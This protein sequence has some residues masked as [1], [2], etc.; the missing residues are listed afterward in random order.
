MWNGK[1]DFGVQRTGQVL[2]ILPGNVGYA[3]LDRLPLDRVDEMFEKFRDTKA[4]VFDMR[5]YPKST[6]A[7]IAKRLAEKPF[8]AG[9]G[10]RLIVMSPDREAREADL[11]QFPLSDKPKYRGKT[12]LLIDERAISASETTGMWFKSANGTTYIGSASAGADGSVNGF[13]LPLGG[14]QVYFTSEEFMHADGRQL[15]RIGLLPDIEV[16]PTINGIREGRDEVLEKALEFL[17][18]KLNGE[19]KGVGEA[20]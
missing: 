20:R 18:V 5:G 6:G 13:R 10:G 8:G 9:R 4:I 12:V 7:D 11:G 2:A 17:G 19:L 15:Q 14:I 16:K 1:L 3:D